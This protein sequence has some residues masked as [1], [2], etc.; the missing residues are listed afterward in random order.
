MPGLAEARD[1]P[2]TACPASPARGEPDQFIWRGRL[3]V[4][5]AVLGYWRERQDWWS[6]P[7][8][9]AR[10]GRA[11]TVAELSMAADREVWRVQAGVGRREQAIFD[12]AADGAPGN[13]DG[14]GAA[15]DPAGSDRSWRLL[16][17]AD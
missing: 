7:S 11:S 10:Q 15:V 3:Y 5:S 8:A 6:H 13:G 2:A 16:R 1:R 4:I 14:P 17:L 9:L 12:L